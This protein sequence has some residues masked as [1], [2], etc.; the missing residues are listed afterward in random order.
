MRDVA[1]RAGVSRS[2][3]S[4]VFRGVPGASPQTRARVLAAAE[5]LGYRPDDRARKLRSRDS[6]LIGVTLTA[7]H[8]FHVGVTEALHQEALLRGY[9]L[10]L[11]WTT[12]GRTLAN[13]VDALLAQ[14][15]AALILI[16]PT[17]ADD[18]M[19]MLTAQAPDVPAIIVDRHFALPTVDTLR[20][21]DTAGLRLSVNH[22]K[23]LGH[24]DIWYLDGLGYVS[25]DPRR[26]AYVTA[27]SEAGLTSS[28]G[29][30][31][32]GGSRA[33]GAA[34]AAELLAR[35]TLPTAFIAYNDQ[36]GFGLLD[37]LVRR[38]VRVPADVSVVGFDNVPESAMDHLSLTT[39]E[40]R[41][42]LLARAVAEVLTS[43]L[44]GAPPRGLRLIPPGPLVVRHS[45]GPA[46]R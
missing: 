41:A 29:I 23:E 9:E 28:I 34:S 46:P 16:G 8:P 26:T 21:D 38:G 1:V 7:V 15:C 18:E 17:A 45:T 4:T 31:P 6:R 37:V 13:A 14:R 3:V 30:V 5:E 35:G 40:Q 22:L 10:S 42:D 43:R 12:E 11:S 24:R 20:V 33:E 32:S 27:M 25:A 39:V 19:A 2:L 36:C 44:Q